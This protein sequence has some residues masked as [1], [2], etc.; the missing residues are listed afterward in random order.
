MTNTEAARLV[1]RGERLEYL[2]LWWNVVGVVVLAVAAL[3]ATS[4]ALAGFGLDSVIE[5]G[6][7]L[8]VLWE[9]RGDEGPRRR[10][11]LGLLAVA[12]GALALYLSAQGAVVIWTGHH[13]GPSDLGLAWTAA[14][15]LVM[16]RL[17][18]AKSRVGEAL[19]NAVLV[20][21]GHVTRVDAI[22]A[23][24]VFVGVVA[25]ATLGW[26]WADPAAG[27][28]LVFYAVRE[29]HSLWRARGES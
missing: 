29:S 20:G 19:G 3:A 22:L 4:V 26:W 1:A 7:S 9:L 16:W 15:A 21:E 18:G 17:A 12:F 8:V 2:T 14:T 28:V 11:A 5:I 25:N 23:A 24:S 13:A 6:A 27:F 10:R